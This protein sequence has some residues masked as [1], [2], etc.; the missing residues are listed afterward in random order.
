VLLSALCVL[1]TE[2]QE[3]PGSQTDTLKHIFKKDSLPYRFPAIK[4]PRPR[5]PS[6]PNYLNRPMGV[7]KVTNVKPKRIPKIPRIYWNNGNVFNLTI[8]ETAFVNWNAGG[9]SAVAISGDVRFFRYLTYKYTSWNN[10]VRVGYGINSQ[11]GQQLRKSQDYIRLSSSFGHRRDTLTNW[12]YSVKLN[13][14]T[15]INRGFKYP[16]RSTPISKFMAPGYLLFGA[17]SSYILKKN[18]FN[19]YISPITLKATLV[20]DQDLA[21]QGAFG[22]RPAVLD[23]Q[24]NILEPG[25]NLLSEFGFLITHDWETNVANNIFMDHRLIL[26]TDYLDG[27]GE[28][29]VDWEISFRFAINKFINTTIGTHLIWDEDVVF[30][31]QVA[32]DGTVLYPGAPRLQFKQNLSLG[33]TLNF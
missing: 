26:Y 14:N 23:E 32:E 24:G 29:D 4:Y 9:N 19:L 20:L 2:A 21:D 12:F 3:L 33:M 10:E 16:D 25:S 31:R 8:D 17:G 5:Y 27:F 30:D 22:V 28:I 1:R 11:E 13:L 18:A 15:Q 6:G 7:Q